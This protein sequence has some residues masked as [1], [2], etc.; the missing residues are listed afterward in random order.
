MEKHRVNGN[1]AMAKTKKPQLSP[2]DQW[3]DVHGNYLYRFA[4]SRLRNTELAENAVQETLL[5]ALQAR[6]SFSGN[7]SERTWLIGILKHKI[8]DHYR[9]RYREI[10]VTDLQSDEKAID[11]FFDYTGHPKE[12]PSNWLPNPREVTSKHEFWEVFEKCLKKLPKTTA[13]V[14]SLREMDHMDTKKI[15]KIIGITSTNLWVILHRARL[16]L[17][18]CLEAN[19]FQE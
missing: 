17:R 3:V 9:K 14:F 5:A 1:K 4:L 11:S 16:Q 15:C 12:F 2:A 13:D 6:K 7:S 8:I 19:W 10:P 18:R